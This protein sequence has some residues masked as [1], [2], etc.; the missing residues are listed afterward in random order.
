MEEKDA[1]TTHP[2]PEKVNLGYMRLTDAAPL[3]VAQELGLFEAEG[4][5]VTLYQESSWANLRDKLITGSL[6][7]AQM[8]APLLAMTTV[9]ASGLRA[10]LITGLVLSRNG[11]AITLGRGLIDDMEA[12][13]CRE[14]SPD[15]SL[16]CYAGK[17]GR[18]ITLASVHGFSTHTLLLY[19]WLQSAGLTPNVDVKIVII[20][21]SQMVDSL[22]HGII[23]G[24]CVGEPWNTLAV[25]LG[26]G[27]VVAASSD[28][29][30][31]AVEK[32][33][34]V[35]E[36]WHESHRQ[37]HLKLRKALFRA[38]QWLAQP[39]SQ[40]F[41]V[42]LMAGAEYLDLPQAALRPAITGEIGDPDFLRFAGKEPEINRPDPS[43]ALDYLQRCTQLIGKELPE[44]VTGKVI[45]TVCRT[46]L[47]D[48]MFFVDANAP[49]TQ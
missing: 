40:E 42:R 11:N 21:P 49:L 48:E 20:P 24:F 38:C 18:V 10:P 19:H 15:R 34:A 7:A 44:E 26:I 30:P 35:T 5:E 33:L 3:I 12:N 31:G 13:G 47:F 1:Q 46:D 36:S 45:E 8:L 4:I 22:Q 39:G 43:V 41:A 32:V 27:E 37:I 9:G 25:D 16:A 14:S 23:D 2:A 28:I 17:T 6:D 29:W